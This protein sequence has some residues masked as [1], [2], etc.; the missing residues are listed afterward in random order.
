MKDS[1]A[2]VESFLFQFLTVARL[3]IHTI[4]GVLI[5]LIYYQIG[6][7]AA[8]VLDNIGLLYFSIMFLMFTAFSSMILTCK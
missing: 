5:G 7:D 8:Y 3:T 1:F 6:N 2:N 4:V